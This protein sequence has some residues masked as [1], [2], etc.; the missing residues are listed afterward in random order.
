MVNVVHISNVP[1]RL[2]KNN[3]NNN[4]GAAVSAKDVFSSS[5]Q[6]QTG[7]LESTVFWVLKLSFLVVFSL[8]DLSTIKICA[9]YASE[10]SGYA[11]TT[12][13]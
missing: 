3:N 8:S 7:V 5:E 10:T 2:C 1:S 13:H 6:T 9:I 4:N 11:R 12:R